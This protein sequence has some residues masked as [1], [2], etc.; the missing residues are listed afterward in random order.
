MIR[1]LG[2]FIGLRN[3]LAAVIAL[4]ALH[5]P[6]AFAGS[7]MF[8]EGFAAYSSGDIAT[9]YQ[10]WRPLAEHGDAQAQFALG[11]LYYGGIGVAVDHT[12]SSYWF[13]R[14][15]EQGHAGAQYNLGNAYKR[16]EGV[17]RND[18]M[19]VHW[20]TKA[21][22]QGFA[23][24]EFNLG[25]AYREG[26]GV[27]KDEQKALRF[28]RQSAE[29]GHPPAMAMIAELDKPAQSAGG[30]DCESWL[31]EQP[32]KAYTLQLMSTSRSGDA[33]EL[34]RQHNLAGYAVCSY[35]HEGKTRHALLLGA[36]P[37]IAAANEAVA[38]LPLE[39]KNGKPWVRKIK[40]VRQLV[41]K[42][43]Q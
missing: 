23:V 1:Q 7:P 11:T 37:S 43:N 2:N 17:R 42:A 4:A 31:G 24:A 15:A 40:T 32:Q 20:W 12:E 29:K 25:N 9:A 27:D 13:H 16:G 36:Y 35:V 33:Y 8:E 38:G 3:T 22:E 39:L 28:Y 34:A 18:A 5:L 14:A 10:L 41:L 6:Q 26:A 21:A 30:A 19:A